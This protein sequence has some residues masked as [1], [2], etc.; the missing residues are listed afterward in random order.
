MQDQLLVDAVPGARQGDATRPT[1]IAPI[2][3]VYLVSRLILLGVLLDIYGPHRTILGLAGI[4]DGTHYLRIAAHSYPTVV[5][6]HGSSVIAFFPLYPLLVRGIAQMF[7]NNWAMAGAILSFATGALACLSVGALTRDR[8]GARTGVRAGWLVALAPGAAFLSPAY[9]EGLAISLCAI[10]LIMLDR[11]MFVA[12]GVIGALATA[13]SPLALPIV[14][15]A[16]W[17]AWHSKRRKAWIAPILASSGFVSYCLY[18]WAHVGTPFA[19]FDAERI[20]WGRHHFDLFAPVQWFTTWSGVTIVETLCV[21]AA[22]GGMWAM[23]RARVPGTWWAFTLPFLASV[24]FDS[25]LWLTPRLLLSAFTLVA[26][27]AIVLDA[28]RFRMLVVSST[29][30]MELV[31]VAYVSMPGFIYKP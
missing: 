10:A 27:I 25:A 14:V 17:G 11:R 23:R 7:G 5:T 30:L 28:K 18:L 31:S 16:G 12:A 19:W 13:T 29:V 24:V 9:A 4:W 15:A 3:A 21:V 20:G 6:P 22:L 2:L 8:A 26:A 1:F